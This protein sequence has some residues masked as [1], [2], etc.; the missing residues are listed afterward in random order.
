MW[1]WNKWMKKE[2]NR[3]TKR[4]PQTHEGLPMHEQ[5]A[6]ETHEGRTPPTWIDRVINR[7][8]DRVKRTFYKS[9]NSCIVGPII[10]II[11]IALGVVVGKVLGKEYDVVVTVVLGFGASAHEWWIY[12]QLFIFSVSR[13]H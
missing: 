13:R 9:I 3:G 6:P 12:F 1:L 8:I 4:V 11:F 10:N 7:V 2:S 5:E